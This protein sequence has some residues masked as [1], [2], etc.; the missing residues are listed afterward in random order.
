MDTDAL[1]DSHHGDPVSPHAHKAA[2]TPPTSEDMDKTDKMD[3]EGSSSELSD[4]EMDNDVEGDIEPD[5]YYDGGK[6]P[7]FKP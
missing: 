7:V 4:L 3:R 2:L 1:S 5:H 6:I